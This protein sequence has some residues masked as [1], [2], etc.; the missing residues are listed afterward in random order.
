MFRIDEKVLNNRDETR[1]E[2]IRYSLKHLLCSLTDIGT[3]I[4]I[5]GDKYWDMV[6][7][8]YDLVENCSNVG[9]QNLDL[10]DYFSVNELAIF[11]C[12]EFFDDVLESEDDSAEQVLGMLESWAMR[13]VA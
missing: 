11:A 2:I 4:E 13:C 12:D 7:D 9:I 6:W 5:T 10:L 8:G 3:Q 1:L